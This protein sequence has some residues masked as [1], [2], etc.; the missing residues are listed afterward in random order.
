[1]IRHLI[2]LLALSIGAGSFTSVL[3]Q[4]APPGAGDRN[5]ENRDIKDRS[6]ELE[7]VK[8]DAD[9]PESSSQPS[10]AMSPAKFQ[11]VKED[12]ENLQRFENEI[13]KIYT[14]SKQI[15]FGKDLAKRRGR[16]S[17]VRLES[18]LFPDPKQKNGKKADI[19]AAESAPKPPEDVKSLIVDQ[20]N[21]LLR[22]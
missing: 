22:S 2:L 6:I 20:D 5:L 15:D 3:A 13:I 16:N 17:S 4:I 10:P 18:N 12:F 19:Q 11:E 9:K 21:T 7:R 14:M 8:R 1:M